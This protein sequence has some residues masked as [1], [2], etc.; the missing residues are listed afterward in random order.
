[1][2]INVAYID[3]VESERRKYEAKFA[4]H[5]E[6]K[7]RFTI[8]SFNTPKSPNDYDHIKEANPELILVDYILDVP[9][10]TGEVIGISGITLSAELRHRFPEIPIVL[11][12]RKS[13]FKVQ[14]YAKIKETMFGVID[15]LAYKQ[16]VF[17]DDS[18]MLD[19]LY[20][21]SIGYKKLRSQNS[22][23]WGSLLELMDA[24]DTDSIPLEQANSPLL[25]G[26]RWSAAPIAAWICDVVLKYPGILY[27]DLHAA[28]MLGISQQAFQSSG[29]IDIFSAAQY[30]GIFAL[31]DSRWWKSRLQNAAYAIMSKKERTLPLKLG[32]PTALE[33]V[34]HAAVER[35]QCVFSGES[36]ADWVCCILNKPVMIKYSLSYKADNRPPIMDEAR[37]S[38]EA[39]KVSNEWDER[40]IDPFGRKLVMEIKRRPKPTGTASA[41]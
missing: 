24:P 18:P 31:P 15:L 41:N 34:T 35:A 10:N 26:T 21:L 13:V 27:G 32:F 9:D 29:V 11:F 7:E 1:M 5:I 17:K 36:P 22:K 25:P 28:T 39:I 2:R 23:V 37:I 30:R 19:R 4:N 8:T 12:T 3:D 33:R 6:S 14:D 16:E 20:G 38:F 40:F